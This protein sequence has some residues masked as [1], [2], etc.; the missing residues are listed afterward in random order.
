M[1]KKTFSNLTWKLTR[2]SLRRKVVRNTLKGCNEQWLINK[3]GK[4]TKRQ[5]VKPSRRVSFLQYVK[6]TVMKLKRREKHIF[7]PT[8]FIYSS[9]LFFQLKYNEVSRRN[10]ANAHN[11]ALRRR[12]RKRTSEHSL[13]PESA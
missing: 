3:E 11:F 4:R 9:S 1:K 8:S 2:S 5:N 10:P 12:H 6:P 13:R 7:N